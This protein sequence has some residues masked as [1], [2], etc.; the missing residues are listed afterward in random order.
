VG[1]LGPLVAS[2]LVPQLGLAKALL[3]APVSY[4]LSA[5]MFWRADALVSEEVAARESQLAPEQ[6][7]G[8]RGS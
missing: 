1:G 2:C 3:I 4:M 6:P 7:S 5:A 8:G